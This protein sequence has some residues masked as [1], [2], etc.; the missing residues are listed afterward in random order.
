MAKPDGACLH[1]HWQAS[2]KVIRLTDSED[3]PITG[4]TVELEVTCQD[5]LTYMQWLGLPGGS[6]PTYPTV[7][8]TAVE[9]RLPCRPFVARAREIGEASS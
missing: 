3:G 7:N 6:S 9:L 8:P 1:E 5:C 4:W 2:A